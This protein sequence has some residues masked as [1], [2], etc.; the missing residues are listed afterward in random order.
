M[1][2]VKQTHKMNAGQTHRLHSTMPVFQH[3]N[4][5]FMHDLMNALILRFN[6]GKILQ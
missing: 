4:V 1:I 6:E 5:S 3:L 2:R